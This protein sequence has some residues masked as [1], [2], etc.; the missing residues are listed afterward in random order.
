MWTVFNGSGE[1][2]L[3]WALVL[4]TLWGT[5]PI[6]L[7][8]GDIHIWCL[9]WTA[10]PLRTGLC[11]SIFQ[12]LHSLITVSIFFISEILAYANK[13]RMVIRWYHGITFILL[14]MNVVVVLFYFCFF[15][16][17]PGKDI[18]WNIH[19]WNYMISGFDLICSRKKWMCWRW[20]V[21]VGR[22]GNMFN[23]S[24]LS[25]RCILHPSVSCPLPKEADLEGM[26]Q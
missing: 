3:P 21:G 26:P 11:L 7:S 6:L 24:Q 13:H 1:C 22:R 14:G 20:G 8:D 19:G 25:F 15:K 12:P 10:S 18:Y 16:S 23:S 5:C 17:L 4:Y 2:F 9:L